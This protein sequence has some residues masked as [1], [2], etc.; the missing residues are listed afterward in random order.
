MLSTLESRTVPAIATWD[1]GGADANWTTAANLV[2]DAAPMPGDDLVIPVG[3]QQLVK[4]NNFPAGTRLVVTVTEP[5]ADVSITMSEDHDS[6]AP[7]GT[8]TYT[9]T[10]MNNGPSDAQFV[11]MKTIN[12]IGTTFVSFVSPGSDWSVA[13]MQGGGKGDIVATRDSLPAGSGSQVFTLVVRVNGNL[14]NN[15]PIGNFATVHAATPDPVLNNFSATTALVKGIRRV[16]VGADAGGGPQVN[17]YDP[18]TGAVKFSF[19]AYDPSF[20]GGVRVATADITS[21]G[22]DDIITGAGPGGGPHVKIFDGAD[23]AL[24]RSFY[25]YDASFTG[26]VFVAGGDIN[27]D[28]HADIITGAGAG[29]GPHVRAFGGVGNEP[30]ISFYAYDPSFR[31]GVSVA[32]GDVNG[33]GFADIITGA[34][35]GGGPHV[36]VFMQNIPIPSFKGVGGVTLLDS[37]YAFDPQFTGGVYVA[38]GDL[39]KDLHADI[40]CGAGA[41]GGPHVKAFDG[42]TLGLLAS[43]Y[44]YDPEF[45]GGVRVGVADANGDGQLDIVTGAGPGGSP[46][47]QAIDGSTLVSLR[48]YFAFDPAFTGGVF[49][50]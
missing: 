39:N 26:G 5:Q 23:G 33:D 7:G 36:E 16:A 30:F 3:T 20:T 19:F 13:V 43:F 8:L 12:P 28:G 31:G 15:T 4:S 2:G 21:D 46:H 14:E 35:P 1:G 22:V 6:V 27:N 11:E 41:G 37:F 45:A 25:A 10:V 44:A 32:G 38:A 40:I 50:G 49:V 24:I 48:S 47:V 34:G 9:I 42:L 18:A 29:G 17:V